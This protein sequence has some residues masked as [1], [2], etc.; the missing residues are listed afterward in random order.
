MMIKGKNGQTL[1]KA[2]DPKSPPF[3]P[4]GSILPIWTELKEALSI[5]QDFFHIIP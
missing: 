2:L 4:K 3:L 5:I 1:G